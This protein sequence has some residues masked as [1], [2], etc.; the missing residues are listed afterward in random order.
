[1]GWRV[2]QTFAFAIGS[3]QSQRLQQAAHPALSAAKKPNNSTALDGA[4]AGMECLNSMPASLPT[5]QVVETLHF[6]SLFPVPHLIEQSEYSGW[7]DTHGYGWS[8]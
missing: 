6:P 3:E 4:A 7:K 2:W 1:V 8:V 5:C